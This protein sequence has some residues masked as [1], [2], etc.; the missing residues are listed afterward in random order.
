MSFLLDEVVGLHLS[1]VVHAEH[2][3]MVEDAVEVRPHDQNILYAG[4]VVV[5]GVEK[6]ESELRSHV[7]G[8]ELEFLKVEHGREVVEDFVD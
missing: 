7:S 8:D 1:V 6:A 5:E 3:Q 2:A 4:N